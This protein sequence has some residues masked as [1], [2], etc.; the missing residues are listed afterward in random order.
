MHKYSINITKSIAQSGK[1]DYL[2][3]NRQY[4]VLCRYVLTD[5]MHIFAVI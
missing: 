5:G 2:N 3:D 4:M 1:R